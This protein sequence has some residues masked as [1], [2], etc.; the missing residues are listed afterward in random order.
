MSLDDRTKKRKTRKFEFELEFE[1]EFEKQDNDS[2]Y[3]TLI[4]DTLD[5]PLPSIQL[6]N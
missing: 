2:R 6:K 4:V 5:I 1:L 3:E